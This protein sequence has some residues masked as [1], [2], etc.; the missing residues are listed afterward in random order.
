MKK[1]LY[2]TCIVTDSVEF[3][4]K[5]EKTL[6]IANLNSLVKNEKYDLIVI[7]APFGSTK[8]SRP[9]ILNLIENIENSFC[10]LMDDYDRNGEKETIQELFSILYSSNIKFCSTIYSGS[11]EHIL[12]CSENWKFLTTM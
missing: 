5:G 1:N 7:D 12:I 9:Q 3:E 2:I 6:S 11:K 8:Y 4:Y 10:I